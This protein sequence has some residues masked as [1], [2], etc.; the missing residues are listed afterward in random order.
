MPTVP[1]VKSGT[2]HSK[3]KA[4]PRLTSAR[5]L[6]TWEVKRGQTDAGRTLEDRGAKVG[7]LHER[8]VKAGRGEELGGKT[9]EA[10]RPQTHRRD[11]ISNSLTQTVTVAQYTQD[12]NS[13][14]Q[15]SSDL[16]QVSS[17]SEVTLH[18]AETEHK[19]SE[20]SRDPTRKGQT[21]SELRQLYD[22]SGA[23]RSKSGHCLCCPLHPDHARSLLFVDYLYLL[24]M[25]KFYVGRFDP[26][27]AGLLCQGQSLFEH[28]RSFVDAELARHRQQ[29]VKKGK[30]LQRA[31]NC[32]SVPRMTD[33]SSNAPLTKNRPQSTGPMKSP[34][35][36]K[37]PI[38]KP[39]KK[40]RLGVRRSLVS[41]FG[42]LFRRRKTSKSSRSS[43]SVDSSRSHSATQA[44]R[45]LHTKTSSGKVDRSSAP[46]LATSAVKLHKCSA[47]KTPSG[48]SHK[49]EVVR[50]SS[51]KMGKTPEGTKSS[52]E[53][54]KTV[55]VKRSSD[56]ANK[57]VAVDKSCGET[58]GSL[59]QKTLAPR[60]QVNPAMKTSTARSDKST[61]AGAENCSALRES[62]SAGKTEE[63]ASGVCT[64]QISV[65]VSATDQ[66]MSP[67]FM[68]AAQNFLKYFPPHLQQMAKDIAIRNEVKSATETVQAP[69]VEA[70][71][72][73]SQHKQTKSSDASMPDRQHKQIKA[74]DPS[75]PDRRHK[76]T[77]ATDPS[78]PDCQ[79]K[80]IKA[81]DRSMPDCQH[82]QT[83][84]TDASMPDRQHKQTKATDAS[85]PE[86]QH[87]QI[88]AT[89]A[90]LP[91]P[92]H[93]Q[94][95]TLDASMPD[96]QPTQTKA[97]DT[98][99]PD[100]Q[101]TQTKAHQKHPCLEHSIFTK[102]VPKQTIT[103]L[104][105]SGTGIYLGDGIYAV[106][107]SGADHAQ[108]KLKLVSALE[109]EEEKQ[110]QGE[111]RGG[112]CHKKLLQAKKESQPAV[113][114]ERSTS[115]ERILCAAYSTENTPR[116]KKLVKRKS[117]G[118]R[119]S[120]QEVLKTRQDLQLGSELVP[121]GVPLLEQSSSDLP[122][123]GSSVPAT[124][125]TN[126][127]HPVVVMK[128]LSST[129][130]DLYSQPFGVKT[131][132]GSK[133]EPNKTAEEASSVSAKSK[134]T[135]RVPKS[136]VS[137]ISKQAL[138]SVNP[139]QAQTLVS[140]KQAQT[141]KSPKQAQNPKSPKQEAR[142]SSPKSV[143]PVSKSP[144]LILAVKSTVP[145]LPVVTSVSHVQHWLSASPMSG[146]KSQGHQSGK[147]K[148]MSGLPSP[149]SVSLTSV[150]KLSSHS[151]ANSL[152]PQEDSQT[153]QTAVSKPP[154]PKQLHGPLEADS[155]LPHS[156]RGSEE[157]PLLEKKTVSSAQRSLSPSAHS[158]T[159]IPVAKS[160]T[161]CAPDTTSP[162]SNM[163]ASPNSLSPLLFSKYP[164]S[165]PRSASPTSHVPSC[166][167]SPSVRSRSKS[168]VLRSLPYDHDMS[169]EPTK[170][171]HHTGHLSKS[172]S[173]PSSSS[174]PGRKAGSPI[175]Q[176]K[177]KH[178]LSAD[179]SSNQHKREKKRQE[180]SNSRIKTSRHSQAK[181]YGLSQRKV[182][183]VSSRKKRYP[184][185]D[186]KPRSS[187][188]E[189]T[190][191]SCHV[192]SRSSV[193]GSTNPSR[194]VKS[195]HVK[196]KFTVT[197]STS[198]SRISN[199]RQAVLRSSRTGST[200]RS[201]GSSK[202]AVSDSD[203]SESDSSPDRHRAKS[204]SSS[205]ETDS[206]SISPSPIVYKRVTTL[207]EDEGPDDQYLFDFFK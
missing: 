152:F 47:L 22:K 57:T 127:S 191:P 207:S 117:G 37:P 30:N 33:N 151:A 114:K 32:A 42:N 197:G 134:Q 184:G 123:T 73:D 79:H 142:P 87:K 6:D 141:I 92:Q 193:T 170:A 54:D 94:T 145:A 83:K 88:K 199:K 163:S 118:H 138:T 9:G 40:Q 61:V 189:T 161:V 162:R 28:G 167:D 70:N 204:R 171:L 4:I 5:R 108:D 75:M 188:T 119:A 164:Y 65:S 39:R 183:D 38:P 97:S 14:G 36:K 48:E 19:A 192:V 109:K 18:A 104:K 149:K 126:A 155:E 43:Q 158:K 12:P 153:R 51:E 80:Q 143:T 173:S 115:R 95:K 21:L 177:T 44:D 166:P 110:E 169:V 156:E 62:S 154:L 120:S 198:P 31:H 172:S 182:G 128:S 41:S 86:G 69:V 64:D 111:K 34:S 131:L 63:Q 135:S 99:L 185:H 181:E 168:P 148:A 106:K 1:A 179:T 195:S 102:R 52:D 78:M 49:C 125:S 203:S 130:S 101:H 136:Q 77:K 53:M 10:G 74:T 3:V 139:E 72:P 96:L 67:H 190:S 121:E 58:E 82:K 76:Q 147:A 113:H 205:T 35:S 16:W 122:H 159:R 17:C 11:T 178:L 24:R 160:Y 25:H 45:S 174:R 133:S 103:K 90:S 196:P 27:P 93:K 2:G 201:H 129:G 56:R 157:T 15:D 140:S 91:E 84:A 112:E 132:K 194:H 150:S 29:F 206:D 175:A 60:H 46:V 105:E 59:K 55:G 85:M 50:T 200:R 8:A 13:S 7:Q 71:M 81:K 107:M 180:S 146:P 26:D 124:H 202:R 165:F 20:P 137:S 89:D 116:R 66:Y 23:G 186:S 98:S 68:E 187:A 100:P 144:P 176:K